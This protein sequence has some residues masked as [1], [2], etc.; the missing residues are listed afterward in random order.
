MEASGGTRVVIEIPTIDIKELATTCVG[1]IS[2][3]IDDQNS[4]FVSNHHALAI[5]IGG[6]ISLK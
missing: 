1:Q 6:H 3:A 4:R 5:K 2:F